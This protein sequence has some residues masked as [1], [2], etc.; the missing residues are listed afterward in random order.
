M[1]AEEKAE[2]RGRSGLSAFLG[3][4]LSGLLSIFIASTMFMIGVVHNR[5]KEGEERQA[6]VR[7]L[8]VEVADIYAET[9]RSAHAVFVGNRHSQV[10][11][12]VMAGARTLGQA[13]SLD[14]DPGLVASVRSIHGRYARVQRDVGVAYSFYTKKKKLTQNQVRK[15]IADCKGMGEEVREVLRVAAE[16]GVDEEAVSRLEESCAKADALVTA[17]VAQKEKLLPDVKLSRTAIT[18]RKWS[19][20]ATTRFRVAN[21]ADHPITITGMACSLEGVTF[22]A[23]IM[24]DAE[25]VGK[26]IKP[27]ATLEYIVMFPKPTLPDG[28]FEGMFTVETDCPGY[29]KLALPI[30]GTVERK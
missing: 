19:S 26:E 17:L 22:K 16:E 23:A 29:E 3:M 25:P 15:V 21:Y 6:I 1:A 4:V 12:P 9:S 28:P 27:D 5:M 18:L 8:A 20:S 14:A 13:M 11:A 10:V 30:K 2:K 24:Y 7:F